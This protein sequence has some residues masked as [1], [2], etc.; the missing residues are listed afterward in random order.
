M[1]DAFKETAIN[2]KVQ[3]RRHL[4]A[5]I[6]SREY[7][8]EYIKDKVT[9]WISEITKLAEFAVTQPETSYAEYTFGLKH[10]W[11]YFL[12]TLPDIQDLLEPLES[13]ISRV[14]IP[15]I[16]DRQCGRLDGDILALPVRLGGLGVANPSSDANLEYTS[17]VKATAPL[18]EQIMSQ[19]HQL[20][21]DFLIRS[22]QQEVRA[23]RAKNLEERAVR[24]KEVAP[25]KTRRALDLVNE[26]G[27]SMWLTSLPV[28][29]MGFNL[30]KREFRDGL[31]L[32]YDWPLADIPSTSLCGEPFAIDYAMICMRG[33]FVIQRHNEVRDL[34]AELLSMVCKD[35]ATEPVLQ[36]VEGEQLTRGS[37]KAQDARLDIHARGFW[38]PQRSA[39]FDVRVCHPNA[40]SYRDLEPQQIY[41]PHENEKKHQYSS[42]VLDIEHGTFIPLIFTTTGGMGKECLNYHSRLAELIAIKKGEDYAKTISW[43]RARISFAPL[44]SALICLRGT[45]TTVRKSWDFCNTD[46]KIENTEGAIY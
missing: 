5:A 19:V 43:I 4:G 26:N 40:E 7:V 17:L 9:N 42:R 18:V 44:R 12:R 38:E 29:G 27:S 39:F 11:T 35:V 8:E 6:G 30:N 45:R 21:E 36:D 32:R 41:H 16:T 2:V 28:K 25:Q 34:E 37:N 10:R 13:A 1:K 14:L 23:E 33:G 3:G 22:A 20:P 46:I 15:T 24:L 31:N